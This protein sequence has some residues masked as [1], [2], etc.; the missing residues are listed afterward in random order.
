MELPS[1]KFEQ[2]AFNTRPETEEHLLIDMDKSKHE[3]HSSQPL[4]TNKKQFKRAVTSL[5]CYNGI[6]NVKSKINKFIFIS[7]F[8]GSEYNIIT[9]PQGAYKT[10]SLNEEI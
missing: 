7:L 6:F 8:E 9:I 5:S 4:E 10:K 3:D 2:T 1:K